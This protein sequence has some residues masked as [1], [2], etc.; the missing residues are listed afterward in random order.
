MAAVGT[1]AG[2]TKTPHVVEVGRVR[3]GGGHLAV[4][5]GPCAVE[6]PEQIR[7]AAKVA[8]RLGA[9][10]LRAGAFWPQGTPQE[11]QGLGEAALPMLRRAGD[12]LDMPVVTAVTDPRDVALVAGWCDMIEIGAHH[13]HNIALLREATM[14]RRPILLQRGPAAT[15]QEWVRTAAYVAETGNP[16]VVLCETGIRCFD[17]T[18]GNTLDLGAVAALK[19]L[20]GFPVVVYPCYP[21]D[22]S[23]LVQALAR[24]AIAA[25]ADGVIIQLHPEPERALCDGSRSLGPLDFAALMHDV[26]RLASVLG[27]HV[28]PVS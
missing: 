22:S 15:V 27:K 2:Q 8:K 12:E 11:F 21:T 9:H 19:E 10:I 14:S 26:H 7:A 6:S 28:S 13:M 18:T 24:A 4:I 1:L 17:A 23:Q 25:G 20:T 16:Q 5:A 3:I